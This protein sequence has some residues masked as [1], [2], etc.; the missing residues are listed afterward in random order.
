MSLILSGTDGV[1]G[2]SGAIVSGTAV[3][4]SGTSVDFTGIPSW[5]KRITVMFSGVSTNGTSVIL[6]QLGT[7]GGVTTSGY[8]GGASSGSSSVASSSVTV[9]HGLLNST[10]AAGAYYG[11]AVFTKIS[12]DTWAGSSAV[13]QSGGQFGIGGSGITLSGVLTQVRIT[14]VG[15]TNTFDAGTINIL[16][17]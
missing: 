14:T 4:A 11:H 17:E 5:V 1:Q 13:N 9:G 10:V 7:A 6:I 8:V 12:G 2:N 3:S 15:G 16:Y